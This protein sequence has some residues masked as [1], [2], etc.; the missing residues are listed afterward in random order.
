MLGDI[1][2]FFHQTHKYNIFDMFNVL[3]RSNEQFDQNLHLITFFNS[4]LKKQNKQVKCYL[5]C[6]FKY[7]VFKSTGFKNFYFLASGF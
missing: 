1:N 4:F 6:L 2:G 5:H 3:T 7:I